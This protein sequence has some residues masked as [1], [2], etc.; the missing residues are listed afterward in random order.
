MIRI[1]VEMVPKGVGE[2][3]V[4]ATA[5]IWNTGKGT[6][7]SGRY[8]AKFLSKNGRVWRESHVDGFSRL[9]CSVWLLIK[10]ALENVK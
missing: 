3:R 9:T 10:R 5:K 2:P 1:T 8:R 6:E 7:S 4:I